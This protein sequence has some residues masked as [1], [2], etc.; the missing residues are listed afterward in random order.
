MIEVLL[1]LRNPTEALRHTLDS[2]LRQECRDFGVLLSDNH[3]TSGQALIEEA[4]QKLSQA[5][6]SV[7][8]L[9]PPME[10]KR[11]EHWNW[12]H[13]QS[14]ADWL[15]P[16]FA[17]D[18][19]EPSYLSRVLAEAKANPQG[20]YV[21][22]SFRHHQGAEATECRVAWSG[23]YFPPQEMGPKVLCYGMQFGPP[24]VAAYRREAFT[25]MG[26]YRMTL[27]I[28]ADSLLFCS[29]AARFGAL[30]LSDILAHFHLHG[31]RFSTTLPGRQTAVFR[32]KITVTALLTYHAFTEG[33]PIPLFGCLRLLAWELRQRLREILHLSFA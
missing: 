14:T 29:L 2:L 19:L 4:Q 7:R 31:S 18:W 17:G 21:Y 9:R 16:L 12:I 20:S 24:S 1:P 11:V 28:C 13:F 25:A 30:G 10:L 6:L 27:P 26:G 15:K 32:E 8:R 33:I 22:T 23:R 3:S 5:G